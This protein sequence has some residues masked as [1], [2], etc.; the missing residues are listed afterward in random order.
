MITINYFTAPWCGPCKMFGPIVDVISQELN[1]P[2]NKVNVDENK[3]MA[4]AYQVRSVPTLVIMKNG[5]PAAR[6]TGIMAKGQL[7]QFINS[8]K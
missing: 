3:E 7:E 8:H 4:E 1:I 5:S 2:V 6:H